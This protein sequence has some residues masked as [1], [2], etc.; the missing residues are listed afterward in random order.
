MAWHAELPADKIENLTARGAIR[1]RLRL[2]AAAS[3][4]VQTVDVLV[5]DLSLTGALVETR[6]A[7]AVGESIEI[8]VPEA[9]ATPAMVVWR[10][11]DFHGCQFERPI[12]LAAVSAARLRSPGE[13]IHLPAP[14]SAERRAGLHPAARLAV[15]VGLS[16]A[17][18]G[19]LILAF[20]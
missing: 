16:A 7:I 11:G 12:S 2:V 5:H 10:S 17:L 3:D 20:A 15:I 14:Q 9:G 13:Q 4:G 1:R 6:A 19:G 18:W 8:D